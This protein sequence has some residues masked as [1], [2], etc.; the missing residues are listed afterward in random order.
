MT[1]SNTKLNRAA[2]ILL[3]QRSTTSTHT[4]THT[5][6][7][8]HTHANEYGH[9]MPHTL[10]QTSARTHTHTHFSALLP[11]PLPPCP[12][13]PVW[14]ERSVHVWEKGSQDPQTPPVRAQTRTHLTSRHACNCLVRSFLLCPHCPHWHTQQSA[15]ASYFTV[16][17][18]HSKPDTISCRTPSYSSVHPP[19]L[20]LHGSI[21]MESIILC[22]QCY[23]SS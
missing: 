18:T 4:H 3:V 19:P 15:F 13:I 16:R 6:V 23:V 10:M 20:K 14:L 11:S 7:R 1:R 9:A 17:E 5:H 22:Y 21:Q 8:K 2:E 12:F